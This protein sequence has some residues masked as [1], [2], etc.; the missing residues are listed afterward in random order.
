[1]QRLPQPV[2]LFDS[3]PGV[4]EDLFQ[5]TFANV[6]P[7]MHRHGDCTPVGLAS[8]RE[9]TAA[10]ADLDKTLLFEKTDEFASCDGWQLLAHAGI[11]IL[12]NSATTNLPD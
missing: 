4:G 1:M 6:L 3:I 2:K 7:G 8:Q 5:Q 9:M 11:P 10:L 12:S